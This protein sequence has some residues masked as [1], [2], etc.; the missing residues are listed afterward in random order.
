[1]GPGGKPTGNLGATPIYCVTGILYEQVSFERRTHLVA[2]NHRL[3][4]LRPRLMFGTLAFW[5]YAKESLFRLWGI[6]SHK[7]STGYN[8]SAA[9]WNHTIQCHY[10]GDFER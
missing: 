9:Y 1:M 6:M 4:L 3:R 2:I 7:L 8:Y 10:V 5:S